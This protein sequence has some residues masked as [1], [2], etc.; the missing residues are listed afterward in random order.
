[1]SNDDINVDT[2]AQ[3]IAPQVWLGSFAALREQSFLEQH[4]IKVI[5]N[6]TPT[7]CFLNELN[8][9]NINI[10][11]D[12]IMLLLDLSFDTNKFSP[13]ELWLLDGYIERFGRILQ[14]Y[15]HFFY[16]ENPMAPN[17]IHSFPQGK[18]FSLSSPVLTGNLKMQLFNINRLLKLLRNVNDTIGV[19]V[20]SADG[21]APLSSAVA[22]SYLM[23]SYN[24][25]LA[26]SICNLMACRP[27]IKEFN[28]QF[29]EELY[30]IENLKM[31]YHEN[32]TIK[33]LSHALLT[34]NR[35]LKRKNDPIAVDGGASKR[36]NFD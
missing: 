34:S 28:P 19:I 14:N 26:G 12:M 17:L 23:D 7:Y 15:L 27:L 36:P 30:I 33:Q 11:T 35:K 18:S 3:E 8:R 32:L 31:F 29:Y 21:D 10:S 16:H 6:C 4:G 9:S 1:M 2:F 5:I 13:D 24:I 25:N 20:V 22:I